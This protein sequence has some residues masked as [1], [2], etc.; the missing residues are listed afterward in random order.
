MTDNTYARMA[1]NAGALDTPSPPYDPRTKRIALCAAELLDV[2]S[3]ESDASPDYRG[4][5]ALIRRE[6]LSD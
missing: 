5:A 1:G 6:F 4:W 2:L 3:E